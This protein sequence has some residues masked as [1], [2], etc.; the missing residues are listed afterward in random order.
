ML[1]STATNP[2]ILGMPAVCELRITLSST[3]IELDV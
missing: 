1:D 2:V 3:L